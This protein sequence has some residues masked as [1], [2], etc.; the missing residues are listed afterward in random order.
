LGEEL[1][2]ALMGK[3]FAG[4]AAFD[5][6]S[7]G[8]GI[9]ELRI[10]RVGAEVGMVRQ[11]LGWPLVGEPPG[12]LGVASRGTHHRHRRL[13]VEPRQQWA[14]PRGRAEWAP[15]RA[16]RHRGESAASTWIQAILPG[17]E[18]GGRKEPPFV[19]LAS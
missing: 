4:W 16:R 18:P 15:W 3:H 11:S 5:R 8:D 13:Q 14:E 9:Y 7:V 10:G 12:E 6:S 2:P 19:Q 1:V 17:Q